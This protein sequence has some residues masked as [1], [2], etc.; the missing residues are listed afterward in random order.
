M[1]THLF[2]L[3]PEPLLCDT[4][5]LYCTT[6]N[7]FIPTPLR[8]QF[9]TLGQI[10]LF[11][12]CLN[13]LIQSSIKNSSCTIVFTMICLVLVCIVLFGNLSWMIPNNPYQPNIGINYNLPVDLVTIHI[14][15]YHKLVHFY[16]DN[17]EIPLHKTGIMLH[18]YIDSINFRMEAIGGWVF[19]LWQVQN[20]H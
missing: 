16:P 5:A 13:R 17:C 2:L 4:F 6:C 12:N 19:T 8:K 15:L 18:L 3:Q 1:V 11:Y 10:S 14:L 7:T 9:I 20:R